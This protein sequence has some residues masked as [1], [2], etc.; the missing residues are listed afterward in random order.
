MRRICAKLLAKEA[1]SKAPEIFNRERS[2]AKQWGVG[3]KTACE[4][5]VHACNRAAAQLGH[6]SSLGLVKLDFENSFNLCS[7][8]AMLKA[9]SEHYV[10][11]CYGNRAAPLLLSLGIPTGKSPGTLTFRTR[12]ARVHLGCQG[13]PKNLQRVWRRKQHSSLLLFG[14]RR[15]DRRFRVDS[16]SC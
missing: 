5:I 6:H 14:R 12:L 3:V 11:L 7:R 4:G 10:E 1:T 16:R 8:Q 2:A 9:V 13:Q 15:A